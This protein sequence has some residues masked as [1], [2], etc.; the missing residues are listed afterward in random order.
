MFTQ[1]L[2]A[3]IL[4]KMEY[5]L[6]KFQHTA[7]AE[8]LTIV[9]RV[10]STWKGTKLEYVCKMDPGVVARQLVSVIMQLLSSINNFK[11]WPV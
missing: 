7:W 10:D 5:Y 2:D 1:K 8:W 9:V 11:L 4:R 6:R 3:R